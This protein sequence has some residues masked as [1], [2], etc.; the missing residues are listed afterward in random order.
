MDS[1]GHG[2][3][4]APRVGGRTHDGIDL[5]AGIASTV[6]SHVSGTVTKIGYPYRQD[7]SSKKDLLKA[8][9]RYIQ[10]TDSDGYDHRFFYV[11]PMLKLHQLVRIGDEIG[12]MQDLERI[13]PGMKNHLHYEALTMVNGKKVF[14]D[15]CKWLD[16]S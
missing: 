5:E 15:P 16:F 11:K 8:T 13:Y 4:G 12:R 6:L 7:G 2:I 3:Y 10:V 1:Q 9:L 14:H